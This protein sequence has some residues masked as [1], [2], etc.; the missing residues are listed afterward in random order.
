MIPPERVE[1]NCNIT[2]LSNWVP[3]GKHVA[4]I[5]FWARGL[6]IHKTALLLSLGSEQFLRNR[7]KT[8]GIVLSYFVYSIL[9]GYT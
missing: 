6:N 3:S 5:Q 8:L 1:M 7:Y 2:V 4:K 9:S